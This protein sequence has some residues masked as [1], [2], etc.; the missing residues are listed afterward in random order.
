MDKKSTFLLL[1]IILAA[2]NLRAPLTS[3]GPLIHS[4]RVDLGI[5]N[6][7]AGLLTTL[8]LISFA[9]LSPIAPKIGV[10]FGNERTLLFGL[11]VLVIGVLVRSIGFTF[12]LFTGTALI[13]LG[14]AMG[15]VLLP[16]LVKHKFPN[17]VGLITSIYSTSMGICAALAS[18]IS[19]PIAQGLHAGWKLSLACWAGL[20]VLATCIWVIEL[21]NGGT[22]KSAAAKQNYIA[23]SPL[24][25]STLAWQITLFMGLQSFLF[26]CTIAWLPDIL[27]SHGV[28]GSTAGWMLSLMQFVSLPTTFFTPILADRLSGQ[29]GIVVCLGMIY[30][31]GLA[32]LLAGENM[33]MVTISVALVGLAQGGC[34]SLALALFGLRAANAK[35]AGE[36]SGMAQSVGYLLAAVGPVFTGFLFDKVHAW[37]LPLLMLSIVAILMTAA[38]IGAGR[39]EYIASSQDKEL[40]H[41]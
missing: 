27:A 40:T 19:I 25:R 1:G 24:W 10:R 15:N 9:L 8:P 31:L 26:Y 39:N 37:T 30:L 12:T 11:L 18:G 23:D 35:Q 14:I 20:A 16:S 7:L 34:I 32:G 21:R 41:N 6:G 29:R 17:K 5:S 36:L 13:G 3:L 28:D 38:G 22:E 2:C 4:I 33:I